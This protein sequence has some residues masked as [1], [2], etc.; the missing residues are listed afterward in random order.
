MCVSSV[1]EVSLWCS[2][3]FTRAVIARY[4][5][6]S[7]SSFCSLRKAP[8]GRQRDCVRHVPSHAGTEYLIYM[9]MILLVSARLDI[10]MSIYFENFPASEISGFVANCTH[11]FI[12]ML[13]F[14]IGSQKSLN[15]FR[16]LNKVI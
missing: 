7:V 5:T 3:H 9:N 1:V 4:V 16:S 14:L 12:L 8:R 13:H 10:S 2:T 15:I 6:A 11:V